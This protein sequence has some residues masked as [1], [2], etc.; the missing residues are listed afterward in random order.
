MAHLERCD[1]FI[2]NDSGPAHV[3]AAVGTPTIA[4]FGS[5]VSA[6]YRPLGAHHRVIQVDDM[7][8]RPCF[9]HCTQSENFCITGIPVERVLREVEG[10][11]DA[12][13][14]RRPIA[15]DLVSRRSEIPA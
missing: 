9:D 2:G 5:A 10:V 7:P 4:I 6:W 12:L 11:L 3:A 1:L 15:V 14:E 8:C 13:V